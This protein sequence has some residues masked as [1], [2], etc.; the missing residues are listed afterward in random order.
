[1]TKIVGYMETLVL[2]DATFS[3]TESSTVLPRSATLLLRTSARMLASD[4]LNVTLLKTDHSKHIGQSTRNTGDEQF[5]LTV[6]QW[7]PGPSGQAVN[8]Q[9]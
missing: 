7:E 9:Q 4:L 3:F 5:R 6:C 2:S 8:D 1:M